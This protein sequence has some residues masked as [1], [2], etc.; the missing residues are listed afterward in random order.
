M[1][2]DIIEKKDCNEEMRINVWL[3]ELEIYK[4]TKDLFDNRLGWSGNRNPYAP[5][6]LWLKL[7]EALYGKDDERTKELR[8]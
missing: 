5:R 2:D 8:K 3:E 4:A 6:E 1:F 7:A